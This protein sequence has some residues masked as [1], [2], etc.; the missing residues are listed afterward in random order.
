MVEVRGRAG[1]TDMKKPSGDRLLEGFFIGGPAGSRTLDTRIKSLTGAFRTCTQGHRTTLTRRSSTGIFRYSRSCV[2]CPARFRTGQHRR[3]VV[4]SW[5]EARRGLVVMRIDGKPRH[6]GLFEDQEEAERE[7]AK[8]RA[9][10][11]RTAT[12]TPQRLTIQLP[13]DVC[14]ELYAR[15][16]IDSPDRIIEAALRQHLALD[17]QL[18]EH[19]HQEAA[20][21]SVT[22][23]L[24]RTA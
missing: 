6:I 17:P 1:W 3:I 9:E 4:D 16:G 10:R 13:A 5:V 23:A 2:C 21:A 24:P 7:S 22:D 18:C 14:R 19:S 11:A 15:T 20:G 8:V 12:S